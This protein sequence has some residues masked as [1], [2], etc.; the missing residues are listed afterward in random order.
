MRRGIACAGNW[1]VDI[2]HSIEAWPAKS[3]LVRITDEVEG[4]GGGAANVLLALAA[5]QTGLPLWAMGLIGQDRHAATVR[6]AIATAGGGCHASG[7]HRCCA[8]R[9]I[10]M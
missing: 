5:F 2:V 1:I 7:R 3:D 9:P 10:P 4:T 6:A 8:H